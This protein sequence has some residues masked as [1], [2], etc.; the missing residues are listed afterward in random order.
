MNSRKSEICNIDVHRV[1]YAKHFRSK[2]HSENIKEN[3]M[4]IREWFF[5]REPVE[6]KI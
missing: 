2:N 4:I 6:N 3:E 5:F 1:S